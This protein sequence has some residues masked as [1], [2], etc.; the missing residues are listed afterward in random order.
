MRKYI[1]L[2]I[3]ISGLILLSCQVTRPDRNLVAGYDRQLTFSYIPSGIDYESAVIIP[4][5]FETFQ[6]LE[7]HKSFYALPKTSL[8]LY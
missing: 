8:N 2:F 6:N 7:G 1:T 5:F 4:E 3:I